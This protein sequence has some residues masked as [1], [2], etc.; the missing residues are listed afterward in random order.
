MHLQLL[1]K[2]TIYKEDPRFRWFH[3]WIQ[4]NIQRRINN[5]YSQHFQEGEKGTIPNLFLRLKLPIP[6]QKA[7]LIRN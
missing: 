4:S 7:N 5:N 6:K 2:K 1:K 3:L